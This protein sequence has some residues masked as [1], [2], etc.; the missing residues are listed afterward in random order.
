M[1]G[2]HP[3]FTCGFLDGPHVYVC[4]FAFTRT[5]SCTHL[6]RVGLPLEPGTALLHVSRRTSVTLLSNEQP[7][8]H[9]AEPN[10]LSKDPLA[11]SVILATSCN[12]KPGRPSILKLV[13]AKGTLALA[14]A[15]TFATLALSGGHFAAVRQNEQR[16]SI[17]WST[18]Y[19]DRLG[20]ADAGQWLSDKVCLA[21]R[22]A[23]S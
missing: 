1:L 5:C 2:P 7:Q 10:R 14:V 9:R 19:S 22:W 13:K 20:D 17:H 11:W 4:L 3:N 12:H 18:R 6:H 16:R 15:Q 23:V 8:P 21:A